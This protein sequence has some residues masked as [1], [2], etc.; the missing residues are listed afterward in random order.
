MGFICVCVSV[1]GGNL[2]HKKLG[3]QVWYSHKQQTCIYMHGPRRDIDSEFNLDRRGC[4]L[5]TSSKVRRT[6]LI[7]LQSWTMTTRRRLPC[8]SFKISHI[9]LSYSVIVFFFQCSD[10]DLSLHDIG[11]KEWDQ[12][13]GEEPWSPQVKCVSFWGAAGQS[14]GWWDT[15]STEP[16][17]FSYLD[18]STSKE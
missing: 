6:S 7:M 8:C 15:L 10:F 9:D 16:R 1:G 13:A 17:C 18:A 2:E 3:A 5:T 14:I 12:N 4:P 11:S